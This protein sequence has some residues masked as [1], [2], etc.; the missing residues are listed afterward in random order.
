MESKPIKR[1]VNIVI[2][3]KEHHY[4]LLFAWKLR[5]GLAG[6]IELERMAKYVRYFWGTHLK[7]HFEEEENL[8]FKGVQHGLVDKGIQQHIAIRTLVDQIL[9][10]GKNTA[11][12]YGSLTDLITD[13]IRFEERELFPYLEATL[14]TEQLSR[15]GDELTTVHQ[16]PKADDY[17]DVFWLNKRA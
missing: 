17:P 4:G 14:T 5:Q 6:H 12:D 9:S 13:H 16:K 15:I 8:L 3:S 2:L 7:E 1:N 10:E 11:E